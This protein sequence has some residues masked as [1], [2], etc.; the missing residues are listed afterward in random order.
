[1]EQLVHSTYLLFGIFL[2]HNSNAVKKPVLLNNQKIRLKK[3]KRKQ[4][5]RLISS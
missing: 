5:N 1:M 3:S 4:I 2:I